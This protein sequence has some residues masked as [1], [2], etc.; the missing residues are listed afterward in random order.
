METQLISLGILIAHSVTLVNGQPNRMQLAERDTCLNNGLW[1]GA[2]TAQGE[3][4]IC[5]VAC[6]WNARR[7]SLQSTLLDGR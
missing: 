4:R 1:V 6:R 7:P 5:C 3:P 2:P